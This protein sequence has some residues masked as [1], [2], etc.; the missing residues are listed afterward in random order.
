MQKEFVTYEIALKL[1]ELGF[2]KECLAYYSNLDNQLRFTGLF[3]KN[4][5][6]VSDFSKQLN[7]ASPLW[8]Q[9]IDFFREKYNYVIYITEIGENKSFY[10]YTIEIKDHSLFEI[11]GVYSKYH[12]DLHKTYHK[13][14]EQSILYTLELIKN[15]Q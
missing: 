3:N 13:A 5:I 6:I 12:G 4:N 15:K 1:K 14:I 9:V 2:N 8:Q 7:I 11:D 10:T